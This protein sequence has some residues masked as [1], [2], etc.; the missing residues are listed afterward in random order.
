MCGKAATTIGAATIVP[1][2]SRRT[3]GNSNT[4]RL[5]V[6]FAVRDV[7]ATLALIAWRTDAADAGPVP[8]YSDLTRRKA[9]D[10][11]KR[12]LR[13]ESGRKQA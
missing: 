1:A 13:R 9:H 5:G 12:E 2:I 3:G 7:L 10:L 11:Y 4:C 8:R 6:I